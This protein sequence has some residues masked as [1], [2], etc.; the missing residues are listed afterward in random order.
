MTGLIYNKPEDPL[1]FLEAAIA[2]IR[3]NPDLDVKWD[4]FIDTENGPVSEAEGK[5]RGKIKE[6]ILIL[7]TY[8]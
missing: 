1:D 5:L 3:I 7:K 4:T 8:F 6:I 2:K